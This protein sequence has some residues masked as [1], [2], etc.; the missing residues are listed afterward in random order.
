[1]SKSKESVSLVVGGTGIAG[2]AMIQ[3]LAEKSLKTLA[4]SRSKKQYSSMG[5]VSIAADLSDIDS[6]QNAF[7]GYQ[8]EYVYWVMVA[9]HLKKSSFLGHDIFYRCFWLL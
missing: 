7:D 5:V 2:S 1:M 6:L 8:I 9:I 3:L 4:L